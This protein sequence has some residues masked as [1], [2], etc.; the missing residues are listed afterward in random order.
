MD[1]FN[2]EY[3]IGGKDFSDDLKSVTG[4]NKI[5]S[6]GEKETSVPIQYSDKY[7]FNSLP[8]GWVNENGVFYQKGSISKYWTSTKDDDLEEVWARIIGY[9]FTKTT[10]KPGLGFSIRLIKT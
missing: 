7:G 1:W 2:L 5:E 3:F 10:V 6:N 4:W 9:K 8:S